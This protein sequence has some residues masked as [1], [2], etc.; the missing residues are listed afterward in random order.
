M[1]LTAAEYL[2]ASQ[3]HIEEVRF[4]YEGRKYALAHYMAGLAVECM[5]RAYAVGNG[6]QFEGRH[7]LSKWFELARFDEVIAP[8][9]SQAVSEAYSTILVQWNSV[10][11]YYSLGFLR[12]YFRNAHLDRGVRGDVVKELSRRASEAAFIVVNEG[13][14]RWTN[15]NKLSEKL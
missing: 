6:T 5:F 2:Q 13:T 14:V 1:K 3:D 10:Q 15:W 12:A 8:Q 4:L 7:D 11:R 9:R